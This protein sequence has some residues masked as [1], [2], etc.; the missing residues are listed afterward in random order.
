MYKIV[1]E[2][3]SY[4]WKNDSSKR[5]FKWLFTLYHTN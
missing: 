1:L 5:W 2:S 4:Y 3:Y